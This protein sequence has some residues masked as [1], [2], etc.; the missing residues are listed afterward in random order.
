MKR[1]ERT[2]ISA[3]TLAG[4][5]AV[6]ACQSEPVPPPGATGGRID[7]YRS[8]QADVYSD[9]ASVPA[10]MEFT[11]QTAQALARDI[12]AI[13]QIRNAPQPAV[14]YL[15]T[16]KNQ[17]R[18]P[19]GNFEQMQARLRGELFGSSLVRQYATFKEDPARMD[20]EM[21]RLGNP[22]AP[23]AR[24][25]R[26]NPQ[27]TYVLQGDFYETGR[28]EVRRYYFE[29]KLAHL[30]NSEIVFRNKYDLGQAV[31]PPPSGS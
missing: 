20:E 13:P 2:I 12:T 24:V 23:V 6:Q 17:T 27:N 7:P 21:R 26:D 10:L 22:D 31:P 29:F 5:L 16:I 9:A 3:M 25:Q 8:T 1:L 11:D 19:T 15:G 4:L 30:A 18:T 28:D 14:I